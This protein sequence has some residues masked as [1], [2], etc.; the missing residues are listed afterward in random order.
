VIPTSLDFVWIPGF[1]V[2][3]ALFP[4][5]RE[6][7]RPIPQA[8]TKQVR[9]GS[10]NDARCG[11]RISGRNSSFGT[12]GKALSFVFP[13]LTSVYYQYDMKWTGSKVTDGLIIAML[14]HR[15][16]KQKNRR[17]SLE[18]PRLLLLLA[19]AVLTPATAL[20]FGFTACPMTL[21]YMVYKR[22]ANSSG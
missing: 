16:I 9:S 3:F 6:F 14:P 7:R 18:P 1:A 13:R 22:H 10:S 5:E 17:G 11:C 2:L 20:T 4:L 15:L 8:P 19:V 12:V 21:M